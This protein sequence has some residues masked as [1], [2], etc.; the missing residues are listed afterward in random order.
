LE[1]FQENN[2]SVVVLLAEEQEILKRTGRD[3]KTL[4]LTGELEVIHLPIPDFDV[5]EKEELE[6]VLDLTLSHTKAGRNIVIHCHAGIGRTGLFVAHLATRFARFI[7]GRSHPMG[8]EIY[9]RCSRSY[10]AGRDDLKRGFL[11]GSIS[12]TMLDE[13]IKSSFAT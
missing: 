10:Q 13:L 2:I 8:E 4:Y 9:P 6:K 7:R 5:P 12:S 11:L 1:A 3:L